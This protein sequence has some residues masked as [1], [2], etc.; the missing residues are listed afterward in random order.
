MIAW[1][2][3]LSH[4]LSHPASQERLPARQG[5]VAALALAIG[6]SV[7]ISVLSVM[8][9]VLIWL[10][11]DSTLPARS[12]ASLV[13]LALFAWL[14]IAAGLVLRHTRKQ[15]IGRMVAMQAMA[16]ARQDP[17]EPSRLFAPQSPTTAAVALADTAQLPVLAIAATLIHPLV[18]ASL[19][20][21]IIAAA[22]S[23][24]WQQ[25]RTAIG[26]S[27]S[28]SPQPGPDRHAVEAVGSDAAAIGLTARWQECWAG[29]TLA[30]IEGQRQ[31][32]AHRDRAMM[33]INLLIATLLLAVAVVPFLSVAA[34]EITVGALSALVLVSSCAV[35][36]VVKLMHSMA[37]FSRQSWRA[38]TGSAT[39]E[40]FTQVEAVASPALA[41]PLPKWRLALEALS[42]RY[43]PAAQPA[44]NAINCT[45]P[46]GSVTAVMGPAGSGKTSLLRALTGAWPGITGDIRFD[47]ADFRQFDPQRLA[48]QIGY[49]GE[50]A[51]LFAGSIAE[52]ISGFDGGISDARIIAAA[53]AAGMHE[54][55]LRLPGGY[56]QHIGYGGEGL[57][58]A[59]RRGIAIARAIVREPFL[60]L[61]DD[62]FLHLDPAGMQAVEAVVTSARARGA[63]VVIAS[64][65]QR[66][67]DLADML[68]VLRLGKV[69]DF[70][71]RPS[72]WARAR[73]SQSRLGGSDGPLT[74]A[75]APPVAKGE[76]A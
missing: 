53:Q 31:S 16:R 38:L 70:G 10:V 5:N 56:A 58:A 44:I 69:V 60:L 29:Q 75:M 15:L 28:D 6:Q 36:I 25:R 41:L 54:A 4:P 39:L 33:L 57:S 64:N 30:S 20:T 63:V 1:S 49:V 17:G 2:L 74:E 14:L 43:T 47:D 48:E 24:H 11:L 71:P 46:A 61:I 35:R 27:A 18:G 9:A 55:I 51:L 8:F 32:M 52:N 67:V 12:T 26:I 37:A 22:A 34:G 68:M 73:T 13:A 62:P 42:L 72:I 19:A 7:A 3:A 40:N 23:I 45:L 21:G 59:W 65:D 76:V 50:D 66:A